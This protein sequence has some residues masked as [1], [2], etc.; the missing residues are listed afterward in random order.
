MGYLLVVISKAWF[1][2]GRFQ[3][4]LY[5]IG[6]VYKY[7]VYQEEFGIQK[8]F[9]RDRDVRGGRDR[10]IGKERRNGKRNQGSV[11]LCFGVQEGV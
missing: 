10:N 11:E 3:Q 7:V 9:R 2:V 5:R 1:L 4:C 6:Q 8:G